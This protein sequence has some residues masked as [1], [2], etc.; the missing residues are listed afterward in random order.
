[1]EV[2]GFAAVQPSIVKK[3]IGGALA[4]SRGHLSFKVGTIKLAKVQSSL[5][6]KLKSNFNLH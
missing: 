2:G 4:W 6:I 3:E 5:K 1:M